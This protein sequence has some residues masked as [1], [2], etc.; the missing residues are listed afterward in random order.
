MSAEFDD[1]EIRIV[2]GF[3]VGC[4]RKR[5]SRIDSRIFDLRKRED[6]ALFTKM[7]RFE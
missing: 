7:E 5:G 1:R 3:N 2:E 4:E 6:I